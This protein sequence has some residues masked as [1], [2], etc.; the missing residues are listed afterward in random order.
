[1]PDFAHF[2]R[3]LTLFQLFADRVAEVFVVDFEYGAWVN[4]CNARVLIASSG[5]PVRGGSRRVSIANPLGWL[6]ILGVY[7]P[8]W[9]SHEGSPNREA[10]E[11]EG[12][13]RRDLC[14]T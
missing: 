4:G 10:D 14:M 12:C 2:D 5:R 11:L 3:Q 1:M 8:G 13:F 6:G 9:A 7:R